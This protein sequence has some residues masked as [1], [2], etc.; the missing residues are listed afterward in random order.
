VDSLQDDLSGIL[1]HMNV[2]SEVDTEGVTPMCH[3]SASDQGLRPDI[4][5]PSLDR[6][7]VLAAANRVEDGCF[8]VP[9]ILPSGDES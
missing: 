9:S 8:A 2:L 4:V 1:E 3:V 5:E 7:R 6:E